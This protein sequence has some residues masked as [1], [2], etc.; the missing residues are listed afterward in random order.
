MT[1]N[2]NGSRGDK[3]VHEQTIQ[4]KLDECAICYCCERH[5]V[6]KPSVWSPRDSS[7]V[8]KSTVL[9]PNGSVCKCNCRHLARIICR[10]HPQ[11]CNPLTQF[12]RRLILKQTLNPGGLPFI[13]Q[14]IG[15]AQNYGM[16]S[17]WG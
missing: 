3:S 8:R 10:Q 5:Q 4:R 9:Q 7:L 11:S 14:D 2:K 16:A 15:I 1:T 13:K 12:D 6:D 17:V